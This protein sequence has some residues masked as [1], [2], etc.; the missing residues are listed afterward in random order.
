M[1]HLGI[2]SV[3]LL[4]ACGGGSSDTSS[5]PEPVPAGA[6]S[7]VTTDEFRFVPDALT[8]KAG[9]VRIFLQNN[10]SYPH[11]LS[12]PDL[13]VTSKTVSGSPGSTSTT[14]T[15]HADK[16]GSYRFVCTFH[17]QAG[18]TGTLTVTP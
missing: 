18:M 2:V 13:H 10:G 6:L 11:N 15:F 17:D 12:V 5:S 7:V 16:P 9:E 8:T 3:L 1:R 14:L 4:T